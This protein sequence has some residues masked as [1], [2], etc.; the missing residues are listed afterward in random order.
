M[1][2]EQILKI[3]LSNTSYLTSAN[4]LDRF[5]VQ[6]AI[7]YKGETPQSRVND[8]SGFKKVQHHLVYI[9]IGGCRSVWSKNI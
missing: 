2:T 3:T 7:L 4:K 1:N 5:V 8:V 6:E 9:Y